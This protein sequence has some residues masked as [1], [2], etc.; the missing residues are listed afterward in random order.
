M[1][2]YIL[3][4]DEL[5]IGDRFFLALRL[6]RDN[7]DF[8]GALAA[9]TQEGTIAICED[10]GEIIGWARTERWQS[11]N[12]LE[13]FVGTA[14]RGRGVATF[15]AAGLVASC[16]CF[17]GSYGYAAVFRPSMK[18]LARKVGIAPVLFSRLPDG[19]WELS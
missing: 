4:A 6:T 14:H 11:W 16:P 18:H 13:A 17:R 5:P 2:C 15:C 10:A 19:K 1:E 12:T 9:G 8:C 7:S 3:P